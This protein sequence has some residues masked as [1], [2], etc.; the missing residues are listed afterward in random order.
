[1]SFAEEMKKEATFTR[2]ENGA[3]ALNTTGDACL[4]LFSTIGSLRTATEERI[5]TLFSEAYQENPLFATKIVFY[6][7]DVRGGLGER[8]TFRTLLRYMANYHTESLKS[9]LDLIGVFGRYDDL[10]SLIGT[11]LEN[12]MWAAMKK[13]F[14]EDLENLNQ[15]N[16]IS[17]LAKWIKTAD[18]SSKQTRALGILTAQKLGYSVYEFK[19]L[20]RRMRKQIKVVECLMSSNKWNE[21]NYSAVP[22]RAMMIYRNAFMRHDEERFSSFINRAISGQEVIHSGALYPYDIVSKILYQNEDSNVLEAQWKQLPNYI[23][24]GTNAIVMADVSGSMD[25]RPLATSIGLAI[26]FAERNTGAY[27]NL[28]MTFSG[29]PS[30]VSLKG[31]T[32]YQKI[33][34][35]K[36]ADWGMNTNLKAAFDKVLDIALKGNV[37]QEEM[38]KSIIVISDM[39]IDACGDRDW[40]FYDKMSK[41]FKK[42]GYQIPNIIF[43]NVD[44]RN[45]VFHAD[46]TRKGV[47]LCSGQS[48]ATFE[49]LMG[50]IDLTPVEFMEKVINSERYDC[51]TI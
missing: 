1:M 31:E 4:D 50:C 39:E 37:P 27:H 46:S 19:R 26:Y 23:T 8:Q 35:V 7:R 14:L 15:G 41:K 3:V 9:N 44:S 42:H 36:K 47:Q 5:Q 29:N 22:S 18:A 17:L 30:I 49:Q 45:N 21:I 11:P 34:N 28:F 12:D 20:I 13:Q 6:A 2:T 38:P 51:I 48:I 24:E 25:G 10:Y 43:W 32:L 40:S 33:Y 16:A